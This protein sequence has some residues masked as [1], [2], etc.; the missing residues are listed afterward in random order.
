MG[1]PCSYHM[2]A[3]QHRNLSEKLG[4]FGIV[5]GWSLGFTST[6][7]YLR[8]GFALCTCEKINISK[9]KTK[10]MIAVMMKLESAGE[11]WMR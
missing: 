2:D 3:H 11:L 5:S 8:I 7:R 1:S 6:L 9:G 4:D 10:Q